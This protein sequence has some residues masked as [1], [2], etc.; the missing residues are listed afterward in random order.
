MYTTRGT[1]TFELH[2]FHCCEPMV[3]VHKCLHM[4]WRWWHFMP[5]TLTLHM[6]CSVR[7]D[8]LCVFWK[9]GNK[10]VDMPP[11]IRVQLTVL[12]KHFLLCWQVCL[13][14]GDNEGNGCELSTK[15]R[16][17]DG[18]LRIQVSRLLAVQKLMH[19]GPQNTVNC[20]ST[21]AASLDSRPQSSAVA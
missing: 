5:L 18:L 16:K 2:R 13:D 9:Y 21:N 20:S 8:V 1:Y 15:R 12:R 3:M 10:F 6:K 14:S 17:I 4:T 11:G 7:R 19:Y